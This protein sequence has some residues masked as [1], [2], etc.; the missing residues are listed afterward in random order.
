MIINLN[1]YI[2]DL[3]G[4]DIA[5]AIMNKVVAKALSEAIEGDSLKLFGWALKLNNGE[6]IDLD[7]SDQKT[8]R[9]FIENCKILTILSKA[10]I[11]EEIDKR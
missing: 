10:Q 3:D 9:E 5:D 7:K 4:K 6:E 11:L 8:L 1:K 2:K